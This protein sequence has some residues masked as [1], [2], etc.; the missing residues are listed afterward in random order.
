MSRRQVERAC[1]FGP[2]VDYQWRAFG[3]VLPD[4]DTADVVVAAVGELQ[5]TETETVFGRVQRGK[6]PG[7]FGDDYIAFHTGLKPVATLLQGRPNGT[8]GL[9]PEVFETRVQPGDELLLIFM[10]HV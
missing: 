2:P 9:V 1:S 4:S 7:L 10:F 3:V 8:F 6:Q 5:A